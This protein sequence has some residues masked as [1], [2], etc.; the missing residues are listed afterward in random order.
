MIRWPNLLPKPCMG[1]KAW[2]MRAN[3]GAIIRRNDKR[4]RETTAV[5]IRWACQSATSF[6]VASGSKEPPFSFPAMAG[7]ETRRFNGTS[8]SQ[9]VERIGIMRTQQEII[10]SIKE[11][12]SGLVKTVGS[13]VSLA[14]EARARQAA[15]DEALQEA[16]EAGVPAK[17]VREA[18]K[19]SGYSLP[20]IS[21]VMVKAG[22]RIRG[23]RSDAGKP[24]GKGK[25]EDE[26]ADAENVSETG[27]V[28]DPSVLLAEHALRL[29]GGDIKAAAT[30]LKTAAK[31]VSK[32]A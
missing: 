5:Q 4:T 18:L 23:V 29:C 20:R 3:K 12:A 10:K 17:Q 6:T 13:M 26:T 2:R 25:A 15:L 21:Q 7:D 27:E 32:A 28:K 8:K 24:K 11:A 14:D 1:E 22:L 9:L 31:A 30:A 19:S 16:K